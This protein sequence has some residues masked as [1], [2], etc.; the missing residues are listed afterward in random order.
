MKLEMQKVNVK[1]LCFN[2]TRMRRN[3]EVNNIKIFQICLITEKKI[4]PLL[5]S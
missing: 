1:M 2:Q 3:L 5:N 4:E